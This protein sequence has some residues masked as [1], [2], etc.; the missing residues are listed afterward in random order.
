MHISKVLE[1][2]NLKI[3]LVVLIKIDTHILWPCH[4]DI[5]KHPTKV[6]FKPLTIS[7]VCSLHI[8]Y[9]L[10]ISSIRCMNYSPNASSSQEM[11]SSMKTNFHSLRRPMNTTLFTIHLTPLPYQILRTTI[12]QHIQTGITEETLIQKFLQLPPKFL[13]LKMYI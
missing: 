6:V 13:K 9:N 12:S 4:H 7:L 5:F 10:Y 2:T 11:W 1:S 8:Y 3:F